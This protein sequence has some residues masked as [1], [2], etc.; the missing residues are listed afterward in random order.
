MNKEIVTRIHRALF[1][2]EKEKNVEILYACESGSRAWGFPSKDSDYD[3]R[4]IYKHPR[5][6]YLSLTEARD[7]I[8]KPIT[9]DLDISGWDIRKA[10]RLFRKSN[11]PLMEWLNSPIVYLVTKESQ[12]MAELIPNH[13]SQSASSYHYLHMARGNARAYLNG[14]IVWVKKY[15]YVLRPL[16]A[17]MWMEQGLGVVPT[18]FNEI[19]DGLDVN[20]AL[21][22]EIRELIRRKK[23]GEE[24]KYEPKNEVISNF[25]RET[26]SHY[27]DYTFSYPLPERNVDDLNKLF[28]EIITKEV[29]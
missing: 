18:D 19:I 20:V 27:Q 2:L 12:K 7:V 22:G 5:D 16:M 13:Y 21:K 6:W 17:V 1:H 9:S 24:L 15:F 10:L 11:P 3:V 8:E 26:L 14:E 25:I 29:Q 28:I 4:F 23:D